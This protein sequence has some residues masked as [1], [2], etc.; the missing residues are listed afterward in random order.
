MT[1]TPASRFAR[2]AGKKIFSQ[3][4]S[5]R[6]RFGHGR[7]LL[8][9][10]LMLASTFANAEIFEPG[11]EATVQ[12]SLYN[13]HY[14]RD[15][16]HLSYSPLIGAEWQRKSGWLY[17]GALFRNSFGQFSQYGFVGRRW[18][19]GTSPFYGKLTVGV[20]HGYAGK[21]KHKVPFN[22]GGFSPGALPSIGYRHGRI[23]VETQLFWTNGYMITV[24][25]AF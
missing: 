12:V 14:R 13:A 17:G 23:R 15:P 8:S 25:Y 10:V 20:L 4:H 21:Y 3:S 16:E 24:G 6:T 7:M 9:P 5:K 2:S 19:F 11:D 18:N 1:I 22:N